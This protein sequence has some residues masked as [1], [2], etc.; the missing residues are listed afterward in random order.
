MLPYAAAKF[1]AATSKG[2]GGDAFIKKIH[3]LTLTLGLRSHAM[4]V[5]TL[6]IM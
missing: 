2:L 4:L 6:Y 1:E 3:Y 5:S